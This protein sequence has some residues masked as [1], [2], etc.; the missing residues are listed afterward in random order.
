MFLQQAAKGVGARVVLACDLQGQQAVAVDHVEARG[1]LVRRRGT[2]T[3][4]EKGG[5]VVAHHDAGRF[6]E[7]AKQALAGSR[8]GLHV[9]E[10]GDAPLREFGGIV[11]HAFDQEGVQAIAG[12]GIVAAQWLEDQQRL[13][14]VTGE[15][16]GVLQGEIGA[17]APEG[18][19]PVQHVAACGLRREIDERA[20]ATLR[21]G[22]RVHDGNRGQG[23]DGPRIKLS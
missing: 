14:E 18:G 19:H 10:V 23:L 20:Y 12:P 2:H 4:Q 16:A 11:P 8:F 1:E 9:G 6:G 15:G 21:D 3:R 17:T 22:K 7:G 5:T 13:I